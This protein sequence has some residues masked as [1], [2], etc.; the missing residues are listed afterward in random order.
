[1][2][3]STLCLVLSFLVYNAEARAFS[4]SLGWNHGDS[5][6]PASLA[7]LSKEYNAKLFSFKKTKLE[8]EIIQ[9]K[10]SL[11]TLKKKGNV[12]MEDPQMRP[13]GFGM[14][15]ELARKRAS[16]FDAK[17]ASK[18][19]K[20]IKDVLQY[21]RKNE[22]ASKVITEISSTNDMKNSLKDGTILCTLINTLNPGSVKKINE[23]KMAFRMM[24]NIEKF[25]AAADNFGVSKKDLFQTVDLYEGANIQKVVNSISAL[26]RKAQLNGF[27]G[28][29][30]G[31][32]EAGGNQ[33]E[34]TEEQLRTGLIAD[35]HDTGR[36]TYVLRDIKGDYQG[37]MIRQTFNYAGVEFT[38]DEFLPSQWNKLMGD[39][40][41][42]PLVPAG[43]HRVPTLEVDGQVMTHTPAIL[44]YLGNELGMTGQTNM[45]KYKVN[46]LLDAILD[47][48]NKAAEILFGFRGDSAKQLEAAGKFL[49]ESDKSWKFISEE[50][51]KN[52]KKGK[53][54]IADIAMTNVIKLMQMV[55]P[56]F[57]KDYPVLEAF[58]EMMQSIPSIQ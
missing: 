29:T 33:R 35:L 43:F 3:F 24:E 47:N 34:F 44:R 38:D 16:K 18:A 15:A 5:E 39:A 25:L 2:K 55:K 58:Q 22:M 56:L 13:K 54:T 6:E 31:P 10:Y 45:D 19:M 42:F 53:I 32:K 11:A 28:P 9:A 52:G 23:G 36:P 26:E 4:S 40:S 37:D 46:R 20:W 14:T 1:M 49:K 30:L 57:L 12:N 7:S 17:L 48:G 8:L 41:K 21:G 27:D 50:L 51:K